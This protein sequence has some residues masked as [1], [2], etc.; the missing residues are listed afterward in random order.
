M[1]ANQAPR[2]KAIY[3]E[4]WVMET[5]DDSVLFYD[6]DDGI[7]TLEVSCFC[8]EDGPVTQEE[9]RD[10]AADTLASGARPMDTQM[11]DKKGLLLFYNEEGVAWK[12][13]Y[14]AA[15]NCAFFATYD[16]PEELEGAEDDELVEIIASLRMEG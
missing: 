3:P 16:C 8:K 14:L 10:L 13:W 7:G 6:P 9:L 12:E 1:P 5:E 15:G 4:T 2:W 11:G